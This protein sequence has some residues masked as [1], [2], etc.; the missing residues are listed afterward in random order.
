MTS[1]IDGRSN[2]QLRPVS[3]NTNVRH[4]EF[5]QIVQQMWR[6]ELGVRVNIVNKEGK[7]FY[8][9]RLRGEFQICRTG[10]VGDYIDA[11]AFLTNYMSDSGQNESRYANPEFDR[12][13]TIASHTLDRAARLAGYRAAESLL[14]RD[15]PVA[16]VFWDTAHHLVSPAVRGRFPT[17]LDFHPYQ[18][19]W[20]EK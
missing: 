14:L 11:S 5:A 12:L 2:S 4:Q 7:V 17:L 9:E 6:R 3:I 19:M 10:W 18:H 20:L 15:A 13:V 16:P 8:D 1:R